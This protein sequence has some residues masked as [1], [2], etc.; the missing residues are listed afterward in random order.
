[1]P[2]AIRDITDNG[3]LVHSFKGD[4]PTRANA[5]WGKE[6]LETVAD[7]AVFIKNGHLI[8]IR[9][10]EELRRTDGISVADRYRQIYGVDGGENV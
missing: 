1:M 7:Y 2:R 8:E 5:Q 6:M 10:L 9:E 3:W 4:V